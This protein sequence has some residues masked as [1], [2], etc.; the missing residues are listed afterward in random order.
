M[1]KLSVLLVVFLLGSTVVF[2]Q[3]DVKPVK[4]ENVTWHNIVLVNFKP[5][6]VWR[7]KEIMKQYKAAGDAVNLKGPVRYWMETGE[8]DLMLVWTM[9]GG[10]SDLEWDRSPDGIK[11]RV[12]MIKQLGSEEALKKLQQ[13]YSSLVSN[14]TNYISRKEN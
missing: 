1:K 4:Y 7:A 6:Q 9:E 14:S 13:E 12:E 11:W 2:S 8:Y 3:E 5:G 10:P